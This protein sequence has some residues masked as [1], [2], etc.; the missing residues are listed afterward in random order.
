[1]MPWVFLAGFDTDSVA[2][3]AFKKT[4]EQCKNKTY[5]KQFK[6]FQGAAATASTCM[7]V[8]KQRESLHS[9]SKQQDTT[10]ETGT[11][12]PIVEMIKIS[13]KLLVVK[14]DIDEDNKNAFSKN[15][16]FEVIAIDG[17][18]YYQ[19]HSTTSYAW[20]WEWVLLYR[21]NGR[22]NWRLMDIFQS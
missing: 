2:I 9:Y 5:A 11:G 20:T 19:Q 18:E 13:I 6:L 17:D 10:S 15:D 16:G 22:M 14:L 21:A 3:K 12:G 1:M 4:L 7:L 8:E